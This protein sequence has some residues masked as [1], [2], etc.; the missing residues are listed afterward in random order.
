[1]DGVFGD[2]V[3]VAFWLL[4]LAAIIGGIIYLIKK[5]FRFFKRVG[6]FW[7]VVIIGLICGT[8]YLIWGMIDHSFKMTLSEEIW[9]TVAINGAVIILLLLRRVPSSPDVKES[10]YIES[11]HFTRGDDGEIYYVS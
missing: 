6:K 1:M 3:L 11:N 2:I 4:A 10:E 8:E 9:W 7:T 5:I